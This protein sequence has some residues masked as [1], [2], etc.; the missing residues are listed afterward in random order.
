MIKGTLGYILGIAFFGTIL[1]FGISMLLKV[2]PFVAVGVV[3]LLPFW[4]ALRRSKNWTH[5]YLGVRKWLSAF[6]KVF[7]FG[8]PS[9][10]FYL[11]MGIAIGFTYEQIGLMIAVTAG[12]I[13]GGLVF[14]LVA[15]E[16]VRFMF[17]QVKKVQILSFS[18]AMKSTW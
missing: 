17:Y 10:T 15:W 13:V 11:I 14:T 2:L 1:A 7:K 16:T 4:G 3:V 12:Y 9:L 6:M 5:E 8:K 18:D